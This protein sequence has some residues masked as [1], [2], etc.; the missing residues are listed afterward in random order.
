[1]GWQK[2]LLPEL[3]YT[4]IRRFRAIAGNEAKK[5]RLHNGWEDAA[6]TSVTRTNDDDRN[7]KE[8]LSNWFAQTI[9]VFGYDIS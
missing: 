9:R 3:D 1:M 6:Y 2:K 8:Q 7:T 5:M 4:E